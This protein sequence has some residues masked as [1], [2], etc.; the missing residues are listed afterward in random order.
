LDES[1]FSISSEF[2]K[3]NWVGVKSNVP[4][5]VKFKVAIREK[6][7]IHLGFNGIFKSLNY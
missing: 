5:G 2:N 6:V 3:I 1:P 4:V 7:E